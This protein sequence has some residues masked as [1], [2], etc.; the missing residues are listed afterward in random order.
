ML[1]P[2]IPI[3]QPNILFC[4]TFLNLHDKYLHLPKTNRLYAKYLKSKTWP[5]Y[6]LQHERVPPE[7][8]IIPTDL[9]TNRLTFKRK[10]LGAPHK[11]VH[12]TNTH[13]TSTKHQL[14]H[15]LPT[16][17]DL[18][19]RGDWRIIR[20]DAT[21][22]FGLH[23]SVARNAQHQSEQTLVPAERLLGQLATRQRGGER[24]MELDGKK[25]KNKC[26]ND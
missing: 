9:M 3:M 14:V 11:A 20:R 16:S 2:T 4:W 18:T 26:V 22:G 15:S 24:Q 10:I 21:E 17:G 23:R 19:H 8:R 1:D 6:S 12:S 5:W 25:Q 13:H 7:L